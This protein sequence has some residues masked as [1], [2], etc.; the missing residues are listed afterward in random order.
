[1]FVSLSILKMFPLW[2]Y[3]MKQVGINNLIIYE[4]VYKSPQS[5]IF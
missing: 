3:F 5:E 2:C 1:M 4:K